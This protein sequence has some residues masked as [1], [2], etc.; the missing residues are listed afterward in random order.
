LV[1]TAQASELYPSRSAI[2]KK[3][4]SMK[5]Q[6]K[7]KKCKLE[8]MLRDIKR[9]NQMSTKAVT[10]IKRETTAKMWAQALPAANRNAILNGSVSSHK[11]VSP[12]ES[13]VMPSE[14]TV[15]F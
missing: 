6:R 13:S 5:E 12:F 15:D 8:S 9:C 1:T 3:E 7:P 11:P 4:D 14:F 2:L 10:S